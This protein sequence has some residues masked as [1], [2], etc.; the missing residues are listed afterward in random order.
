[1]QDLDSFQSQGVSHQP[2]RSDVFPWNSFSS[3]IG[4]T[5]PSSLISRAICSEEQ[6]L[7]VLKL[8][9]ILS[10]SIIHFH[11]HKPH[12]L[13]AVKH[14]FLTT[15][16]TLSHLGGEYHMMIIPCPTLV[17]AWVV[18]HLL[19]HLIVTMAHKAILAQVIYHHEMGF[20]F[21]LPS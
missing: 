2:L 21:Y 10:P 7:P 8:G 19:Y 5:I 4:I 11:S 12:I 16:T 18:I 1:M 15:E 17:H 3:M 20:L 6:Q 9:E 14:S 13:K